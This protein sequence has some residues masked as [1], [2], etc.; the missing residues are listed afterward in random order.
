M[1]DTLTDAE[2]AAMIRETGYVYISHYPS[3]SEVLSCNPIGAALARAAYAKGRASVDLDAVKREAAREAASL[4]WYHATNHV[5]TRS[6][7]LRGEAL[8]AAI[9]LS[10]EARDRYFDR[11]HSAASET[12]ALNPDLLL[13]NGIELY[14]AFWESTPA[15]TS[16]AARA[17]AALRDATVDRLTPKPAPKPAPPMLGKDGLSTVTDADGRFTVRIDDTLWPDP[18][19]PAERCVIT[20]MSGGYTT[21][22]DVTEEVLR[23][24]KAKT[25]APPPECRLSDG[26]VVTIDEDGVEMS[27][28]NIPSNFPRVAKPE[29]WPL[30]IPDLTGADFDALKRFAA[31]HREGK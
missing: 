31:A 26:S 10:D 29:H 30:L 18:L 27:R 7:N 2:V 6:T 25:P 3:P 11:K 21:R 28:D 20:V 23:M 5:L 24:R 4:A 15:G 13:M 17:L 9:L 1:T 16:R 8:D 22:I 12:D 19:H 14:H